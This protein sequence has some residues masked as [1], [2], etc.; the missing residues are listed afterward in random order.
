[1]HIRFAFR[2]LPIKSNFQKQFAV[3]VVVLLLLLLCVPLP[4]VLIVAVISVC[5]VFRILFALLCIAA[6]SIVFVLFFNFGCLWLTVNRYSAGS[7]TPS[8]STPAAQQ[9]HMVN[10]INERKS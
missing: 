2:H 3:A 5:L 7:L 9:R 4:T 10:K 1:M 8:A 6:V